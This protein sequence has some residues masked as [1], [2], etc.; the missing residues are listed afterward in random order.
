M[1]TKKPSLTIALVLSAVSLLVAVKPALADVSIE[2]I[3]RSD[4]ASNDY[5][6]SWPQPTP[7]EADG[8]RSQMSLNDTGDRESD[9][10]QTD[11][12]GFEGILIRI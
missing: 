7:D 10:S 8:D 1:T 3:S 5:Q 12:D 11:H 4:A 2:I 9:E 6:S